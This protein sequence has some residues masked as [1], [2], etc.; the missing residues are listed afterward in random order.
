MEH[1]VTTA[2][3]AP[4]EQ[5]WALFVDVER[6]PEMT[7]SI[8]AARRVDEGPL[9]VGSEAII[10]QPRLPKASW[11]VTE[12]ESGHSFTWETSALGITTVGGHIVEPEGQGSR[13][14]LTLRMH[15]PLARLL[16]AITSRLS[17][18]Y[19]AMEMEGFRRAAESQRA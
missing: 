19:L 8:S 2:A 1:H 18:R 14:T 15:G 5:V 16:Y 12:L 11:R 4:P 6:W 17:R 7:K 10:E 3:D 9:R 13:I